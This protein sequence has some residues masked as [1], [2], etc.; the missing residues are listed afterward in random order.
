MPL[1]RDQIDKRPDVAFTAG[2]VI[3]CAAGCPTTAGWAPRCTSAPHTTLPSV[4]NSE[5]EGSRTFTKTLTANGDFD[6]MLNG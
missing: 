6:E 5:K 1:R 3:W 4:Q 2:H